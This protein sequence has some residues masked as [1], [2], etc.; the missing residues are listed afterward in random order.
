MLVTSAAALLDLLRDSKILQP[1]QLQQLESELQIGTTD[2]QAAADMLLRR[3][4]LTAYQARQLLSAEG[5]SLLL[6]PYILLEPLGEGGMGQVF[7][8]RHHVLERVVALKLIRAERLSNDPEAVRRFQREAKAAARLSH[9]NIVLIYDADCSGDTYYIAMEYVEGTDLAEW[10]KKTGPLAVTQACEFIRQAALG[11]QAAHEAGMVHRDIKPSNLLAA[12]LLL[13]GRERKV[14][15]GE[16]IGSRLPAPESP[17][18]DPVIKITDMGLVRIVQGDEARSSVVSLTQEGSI[19]G[20]PDYIAPEQARNAH[21]VDIRAD[22]YS[23]GCTFYY[24][25]TGQPP[26]ADG[27][28]VEKLL[29]HQ[30]DD[31]APVDRL[32]RNVPPDVA[33]LVHK[34]MAKFPRDRYQ[35]P[36]ELIA[37]LAVCQPGKPPAPPVTPTDPQVTPTGLHSAMLQAPPGAAGTIK[38]AAPTAP[39]A[40]P[41]ESE[42]TILAQPAKQIAQ[43]TGHIGSVVSLAF[44]PQR[45]A[46]A[47][48]GLDGTTRLWEFSGSKPRVRDVLR[49]HVGAVHSLVFSS[50]GGM[51]AAGSGST[52]GLIWIGQV[53]PDELRT[54]SI[55]KGHLGAVEAVAFSPDGRLLAS[56]SHDETVRVWELAAG[57]SRPLEVLKGHS[58]AVKAV[59]FTPDGKL[60]ASAAADGT[61]RLW[62]INRMWSKERAVLTHRAAVNTL[63]FSPDGELL[64]TGGQDHIVRVWGVTRPTEPQLLAEHSDHDGPVRLLLITSDGERLLAVGEGRRVSVWDEEGEKIEE[65][66]VP[67]LMHPY[68]A[69]TLDGRYLANGGIDGTVNVYRVAEKRSPPNP[70]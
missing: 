61:V 41:G 44:N 7:K 5:Q 56:G 65:W 29:M 10:V 53:T 17:L 42:E 40:K 14:Q 4:W 26:F 60:I 9:P 64:V 16:P 57:S 50:D 19:V 15:S 70:S 25:L 35:T 34:L 45:D 36:A 68:F 46:L 54:V 48:G 52:D 2:P 30:L 37:A 20:T 39:G 66:L 31:P 27:S 55:C 43:L 67:K 18:A 23:L 51:L 28:A 38:R 69:F 21:R 24:L 49:K 6:G 32:R 63:A 1:A 22:L 47:T 59:A 13:N 62:D 3:N 8:A 58:N 33:S 12:G 11:L